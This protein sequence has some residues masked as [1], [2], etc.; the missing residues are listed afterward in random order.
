MGDIGSR[1]FSWQTKFG[2]VMSRNSNSILAGMSSLSSTRAKGS[3]FK[4]RIRRC[5]AFRCCFIQ[6][7]FAEAVP[8]KNSVATGYS[9]GSPVRLNAAMWPG[10]RTR[11]KHL[12][13]S[14]FAPSYGLWA[15]VDCISLM[16]LR[17]AFPNRPV[18][19]VIPNGTKICAA[20]AV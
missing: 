9:G 13:Y 17:V 3:R 18:P 20:C 1:V 12:A 8:C 19:F 4:T 15:C 2:P 5:P 14:R 7:M 10:R 16:Y 6:A 11:Q